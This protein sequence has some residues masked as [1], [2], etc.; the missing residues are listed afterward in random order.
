MESISNENYA[1]VL[2]STFGE[3]E[4]FIID[5]LNHILKICQSI[6]RKYLILPVLVFEKLENKKKIAIEKII[7][8]ESDFLPL[9]LTNESGKGFSS[10]LNYGIKNTNSKYIF[11]LDTDD[12]TNANRLLHQIEI[13]DKEDVDICS[14]YM[15]DQNGKILKYPSNIKNILLMT[16][17]GTNPIAH[18]STCIKRESLSLSYDETLPKCED[19]DLWLRFFLSNSLNIKV[20]EFPITTYDISRSFGKDKDNALAQIKIRLKYIRKLSL[21]LVVIIIGIIPNIFRMIFIKNILLF[22]RRKF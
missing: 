9:L 15:Q 5:F 7:S 21:V 2:T 4:K 1:I 19:F 14:G 16:A 6:Q 10:C 8:Q 18:P 11:R 13:M 22:I 3:E 12:R 20:L 17:L